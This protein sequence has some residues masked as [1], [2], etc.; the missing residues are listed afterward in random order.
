M[1]IDWNKYMAQTENENLPLRDE[2][3]NAMRSA[4]LCGDMPPGTRLPEVALSE[5]MGVSRTPVRE[6]I[7]MLE[8]EGLAQIQPRRGARVAMPSRKAMQD[9]LELRINLD[10]FACRLACERVTEEQ[11][12]NI[13]Q[14]MLDFENAIK[15][16][17]LKKITETD[18]DFHNAIIEAA[19]NERLL[20]LTKHL[21][22][23][24]YR[25]RYETLKNENIYERLV[26][27]HRSIYE[28]IKEGKAE[29]AGREAGKHVEWQQA[30][31]SEKFE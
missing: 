13:Y 12:E 18:G 3:F 21:R 8:A 6:A 30:V 23:Q 31:F 11:L 7:R 28:K 25:Y 22:E 5:D 10:E 24:V 17:N 19:N 15:T 4:I 29:E 1:K 26:G 27:E 20:Q 16:K 9:V 14:K 2:V